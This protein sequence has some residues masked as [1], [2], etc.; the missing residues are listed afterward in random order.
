MKASIILP[1]KD[2]W[3]KLQKS[4]KAIKQNTSTSYEI[5]IIFDGDVKNFKKMKR[6]PKNYK[7]LCN[8]QSKEYWHCINQGCFLSSGDYITYL[9]DDIRPRKNWL[10]IA[11][12]TFE[13]NFKDGIGIVGLKTDLNEGITHAP[14]GLVSRKLVAMNGYLS[15]PDVYFHYFGDTE[16]SLRMQKINKY[17]CTDE[18]VLNHDK[19]AKDKKFQD[20][21]YSESFKNCFKHD[22]INF[23]MRNPE[24]V[25]GMLLIKGNRKEPYM[26]GQWWYK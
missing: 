10:R 11:I 2:R 8:V 24:L 15:P 9:A 26:Y 3:E 23:H 7:I 5:I 22:E 18:I 14:H 13:N 20:K 17:V 4:L 6:K 19:P 21:V 12:E 16:L 25:A 1:T